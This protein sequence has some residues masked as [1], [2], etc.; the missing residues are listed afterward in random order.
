MRSSM[1][2]SLYSVVP[3]VEQNVEQTVEQMDCEAE[4]KTLTDEQI[5]EKP[6]V[7]R[8]KYDRKRVPILHSVILLN[9][10][11]CVS[12]I[13]GALYYLRLPEERFTLAICYSVLFIAASMNQG[14]INRWWRLIDILIANAI[15]MLNV[16]FYVR[17]CNIFH[18]IYSACLFSYF[19]WYAWTGSTMTVKIY[20]LHTNIWHI[21]V[22]ILVYLLPFSVEQ[23]NLF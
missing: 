15:L 22:I 13:F 3:N 18:L 12:G 11:L 10:I 1:S 19:G 16:F 9:V 23:E 2:K 14:L 7:L 8:Y 20:E 6:M 17:K 21:G 5:K 4:Y